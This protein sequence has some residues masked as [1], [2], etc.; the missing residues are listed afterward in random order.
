[1]EDRIA[2]L[3]QKTT[4]HLGA[5]HS[6]SITSIKVSN[7]HSR[8]SSALTAQTFSGGA[9]YATTDHGKV[10]I[11]RA[12]GE[13]TQVSI[14]RQGVCDEVVGAKSVLI[15]SANRA[16]LRH[17]TDDHDVSTPPDMRSLGAGVLVGTDSTQADSHLGP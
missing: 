4:H 15:G 3:R 14:C 2:Q 9:Y 11:H 8:A 17:P 7:T 12:D 10:I 5:C 16:A 13:A 6:E 1:M